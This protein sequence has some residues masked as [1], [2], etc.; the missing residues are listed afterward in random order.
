[1][2][3]K[4]CNQAEG[5]FKP[6]QFYKALMSPILARTYS[7]THTISAWTYLYIQSVS[8]RLFNSLVCLPGVDFET[9]NIEIP[10]TSCRNDMTGCQNISLRAPETFVQEVVGKF[11]EH[12]VLQ[13]KACHKDIF[14]PL[15]IYPRRHQIIMDDY[16]HK[17]G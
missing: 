5:E 9:G 8:E 4:Q 10:P 3:V 11:W 15:R 17:N 16:A 13:Q 2:N 7:F 1:M 12:E 14:W 6:S